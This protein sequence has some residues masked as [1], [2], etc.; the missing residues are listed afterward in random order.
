VTWSRAHWLVGLL[1]LLIFPLTGQ[2]MRHVVGVSHLDAIP[3]LISISGYAARPASGASISRV[4]C[5]V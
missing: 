1:T 5:Q 4:R 3:R 2:Y